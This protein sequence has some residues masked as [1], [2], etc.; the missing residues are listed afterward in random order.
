MD[1]SI[2]EEVGTALISV[3]VVC[4]VGEGIVLMIVCFNTA[5]LAA[6]AAM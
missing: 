1:T 4:G 5:L 3:P 6:E 2:F